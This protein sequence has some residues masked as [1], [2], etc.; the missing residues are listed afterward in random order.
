MR[1][2]PF[3]LES[4]LGRGGMGVVYRARHVSQDTVA[5]VKLDLHPPDPQWDEVFLN[6]V[7][8]MA[9][10]DHPSCVVVYDTGKVLDSEIQGLDDQ[11]RPG[12]SWLAM[13]LAAGGS[14]NERLPTTWEEVAHA[15]EGLLLGLAHAHSR[16]VVHRDIKPAN[17]LL[18]PIEGMVRSDLLRYRMVLSDF[19]IGHAAEKPTWMDQESVG[20]PQYM[21]PEQIEAEWRDQGPW[22]DL[23]QCGV[24]MWR[25][26]TGSYPFAA[27]TPVALYRAHLFQPPGPF[28]PAFPVPAGLEDWCRRLLAKRWRDRPDSAAL[29]LAMLQDLGDPVDTGDGA[30]ATSA[31]ALGTPDL[32][33]ADTAATQVTAAPGRVDSSIRGTVLQGAG[34]GLWGLRKLP[35]IGRSR[36]CHAL[37]H[38]LR[39]VE[40]HELPRFCAITGPAGVGKTRLAEWLT[41]SAVEQGR[42]R[43]WKA[44]HADT[45]DPDI[46]GL[47]G[48]LRRE[49]RLAGLEPHEVRFRLEQAYTDEDLVSVLERW[50]ADGKGAQPSMRERASALAQVL[51]AH[52]TDRPLVLWLEDAHASEESLRFARFVLDTLAAPDRPEG[53][54]T[55]KL[56]IVGTFRDERLAESEPVRE[57][58]EE[59]S[60]RR[61][62]RAVRL[63]ALDAVE[64]E[65][66]VRRLLG[67]DPE[68]AIEVEAKTAG[69]PQFAVQLVN[70]WVERHVLVPGP[71]GLRVRPGASREVPADV[72]GVW[73]SR[74]ADLLPNLTPAEAA[75]LEIAS[76]FGRTV[77]VALWSTACANTGTPPGALRV[78]LVR[79]GLASQDEGGATWAFGHELFRQVVRARAE[80]EG[81]IARWASAVADV[82]LTAGHNDAIV[83]HLL[84]DAGRADEAFEPLRMSVNHQLDSGDLR[85][86]V[87][88]DRL[89]GLLESIGA[90][91]ADPRWSYTIML[92]AWYCRAS[93]QTARGERLVAKALKA[94]ERSGDRSALGWAYREAGMLAMRTGDNDLALEDLERAATLLE[95]A[96]RSE[97][98]ALCLVRIADIWLGQG[99]ADDAEVLY[100]Q[101]LGAFERPLAWT[102]AFEPP[103]GLARVAALRGDLEG[104]FQQLSEAR[105]CVQRAGQRGERIQLENFEGDLRRQVGQ[106]TEAARCYQDV[107]AQ[108]SVLNLGKQEMY[109]RLNM[110]ILSVCIQDFERADHE[111]D[112]IQRKLDGGD[113][114]PMLVGFLNLVRLPLLAARGRDGELA[115]ALQLG[116]AFTDATRAC[117]P[118]VALMCRTAATLTERADLAKSLTA[119]AE[120]HEPNEADRDQ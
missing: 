1:V 46:D 80:R 103:F 26:A 14:L 84:L 59:L 36:E 92:R 2:G 109:A 15:M 41:E 95:Q 42:A 49:L 86:E 24:L 107:I 7:R 22:T 64:Q 79:R 35:L 70:D 10:L 102:F 29:A 34:L 50:L 111:L 98:A 74:L 4:V 11:V 100:Q 40:L 53:A 16:G 57:I 37:S 68:L 17:L 83:A 19:G 65:E 87:P 94:A 114:E 28:R 27:K 33:A 88:I 18:A 6:E 12:A 43:C 23:Y 58:A 55:S 104:A 91:P 44:V 20:T 52:S 32:E 106:M 9:G 38:A 93:G 96:G 97:S 72:V 8:L 105:R 115:A 54:G 99:A 81:R 108:A 77:D 116:V 89:D 120:R 21:S 5:A 118:D 117:E 101:T 71:S 78:E 110:A 75:A 25:L 90:P 66:L 45:P 112:L 56:L 30:S 73:E 67:L 61:T 13:E 47:R 69:N 119:L 62:S 82:M 63:G 3:Q 39:L 85:S 31:R 51:E 60:Q 76:A 48:M 113:D